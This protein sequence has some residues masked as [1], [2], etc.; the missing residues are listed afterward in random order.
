MG[1]FALTHIAQGVLN[2]PAVILSP[3]A[4]QVAEMLIFQTIGLTVRQSMVVQ[5]AMHRTTIHKQLMMTDH[6]FT[7]LDVRVLALTIIKVMVP[8]A[9]IATAVGVMY[10]QMLAVIQHPVT[11]TVYTHT[12]ILVTKFAAEEGWAYLNV[13]K[14]LPKSYVIMTLLISGI[15]LVVEIW[16]KLMDPF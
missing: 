2:L 16:Q 10:N 3:V 4:R 11:W 13:C 14:K 12:T 5:I 1:C 6:V 15:L 7:L 9:Q 8:L